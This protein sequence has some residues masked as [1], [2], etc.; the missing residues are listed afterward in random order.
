MPN[1]INIIVAIILSSCTLL[2]R[3]TGEELP[4]VI[5]MSDIGGSE[6]DDKESFVRLLLYSNE[7]D[8]VGLIGANS[9]FGI[10]RGDTTVFEQIID[11]YSQIRP[12]L[13]QHSEGY[14][15]ADDLRSIVRSGQ[16]SHIGMD[17]V[18]E[19]FATDG[20]RLIADEL[21]RADERPLW[22]L[23]W[24]GVNTLAQT[25][26][27]L[28]EENMPEAELEAMLAKLRVYDIAG[29]DDS[30]SWIVNQFPEIFYIRS[31]YQFMAFSY[32]KDWAGQ[33]S[34]DGDLSVVN[35]SW[36]AKHVQSHG[37]Y[38]K[39]YPNAVY[40][41]EGD[42]PSFLY[43]VRTGLSDPE[44]PHFGSW[45]GRFTPTKISPADRY[46]DKKEAYSPAPMF[47]NAADHYVFQGTGYDN[48][49]TPLWR[50]RYATQNDFAA[51]MD[52]S[53]TSEFSEA[54]HPPTVVMNG[55]VSTDVLYQTVAPGEVVTLSASESHDVDGN[56]LSYDWRQYQEVGNF[57]GNLRINPSGAGTVRVVIPEDAQQDQNAHII[58][59]ITDDGVP[60]LTRYKRIVLRIDG[61]AN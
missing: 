31:G 43:L 12:N 55:N 2:G 27:D 47:N 46:M 61:K 51:R 40:M 34:Q 5:I 24:G 44:H 18:G 48:V 3:A 37:V 35:A 20:S 14:P 17:G 45:G 56:S 26:W 16:R 8:L 57:P 11:A 6:P 50:W 59:S 1:T 42:T 10:N 36:Y 23:A 19:G 13:L 9:Q 39:Q 22:V 7:L 15:E 4:R 38:G 60:P 52:W 30:G 21:K 54:N 32:R 28:R 53:M 29:Q 33:P 58:L 49:Y 41:F 25:L